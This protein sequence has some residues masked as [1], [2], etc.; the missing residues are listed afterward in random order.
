MSLGL[1]NKNPASVITGSLPRAFTPRRPPP[2][3]LDFWTSRFARWV[4]RRPL[5]ADRAVG[6]SL[7]TASSLF[8]VRC[9]WRN[10]WV[11]SNNVSTLIF[12]CLLPALRPSLPGFSLDFVYLDRFTFQPR[13]SHRPNP[14]SF[15]PSFF[16]LYGRVCGANSPCFR[17]TNLHPPGTTII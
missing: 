12:Y 1:G 4:L 7:S 17:A 3:A 14:F 16:F 6:I 2:A 15:C 9:L 13:F 11:I 5:S 8:L 10:D